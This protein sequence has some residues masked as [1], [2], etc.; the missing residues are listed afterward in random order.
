M[1]TWVMFLLAAGL[2]AADKLPDRGPIE[3]RRAG[4]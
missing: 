3:L 4:S 2:L 1:N